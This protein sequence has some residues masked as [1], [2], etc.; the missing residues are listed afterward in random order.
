MRLIHIC[1]AGSVFSILKEKRF[2]PAYESPLAGDSGMN[3]FI[4]GRKYNTNQAFFGCGACI[5]LEWLGGFVEVSIDEPFPLAPNVFHN[6]QYWRA[7]IPKGTKRELIKVV[8]FE[9]KDNTLGMF[10]RI[11]LGYFR[12]QL[13]KRPFYLTLV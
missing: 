5:F 11:Q 3:C 4:Y 8:D 2:I 1:S 9:I 7:V 10:E 12:Y 13:K 6:Q